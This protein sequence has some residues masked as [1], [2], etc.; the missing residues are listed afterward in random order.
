MKCAGCG[1]SVD[2]VQEMQAV[3][4]RQQG[5]RWQRLVYCCIECLL[6]KLIEERH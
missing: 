5:G 4:E 6:A 1:G 3:L 2:A